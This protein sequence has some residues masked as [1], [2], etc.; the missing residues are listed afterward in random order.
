M[1]DE[2]HV[3]AIRSF[4][5]ACVVAHTYAV[6]LLCSARSRAFCTI[7]HN[8]HSPACVEARDMLLCQEFQDSQ[9]IQE[10]K[11]SQQPPLARGMPT[12]GGPDNLLTA[13]E[14]HATTGA[15]QALVGGGGDHMGVLQCNARAA[16]GSES[17]RRSWYCGGRAH[18]CFH[19]DTMQALTGG[20]GGGGHVRATQCE[21]LQ[22]IRR[23]WIT[24]PRGAR[25]SLHEQCDV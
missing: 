24:P 8:R 21:L 14:D 16:R 25:E 3:F 10:T 5:H 11:P 4:Y 17:S 18:P 12:P 20:G 22:K 13:V 7:T 23:Q 2:A 6:H 19:E 15:T 1:H 9:H